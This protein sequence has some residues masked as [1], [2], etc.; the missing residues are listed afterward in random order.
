MAVELVPETFSGHVGT[1]FS[2]APTVAGEPVELELSECEV[3]DGTLEDGRSPF[4]LIFLAD[5]AD[6]LPQQIFELGHPEV[7]ELALFM[8]PLGPNSAARMR[9]QAVIS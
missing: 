3:G 1:R 9:Y 6:V 5:T 8:V 4:S 2:A 7:G